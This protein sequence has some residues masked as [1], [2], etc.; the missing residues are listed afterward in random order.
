MMQPPVLLVHGFA[1]SF[2]HGWQ[3]F[4]WPALLE[5]DGRR[6]IGVDLLGHGTAPRPL[7]PE[8]YAELDTYVKGYLSDHLVVDAVGFSAGARI[9]LRIAVENP[10][11]VRKLV[12]IGIGDSIF[13]RLDHAPLASALTAGRCNNPAHETI[14]QLA[15]KEWNDP[16]ALASFLKRPEQPLTMTALARLEMPVLVITGG[17][18]DAGDA[19]RLRSALRNVTHVGIPDSD[20]FALTSHPDTIAAALHFLAR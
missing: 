3:R 4:G 12:L 11:S 15:N 8:A 16:Q 7:E 6:V 17:R 10:A 9:L 18:D 19:K 20:H 5:D 13:E 2:Q 14:R 1:S